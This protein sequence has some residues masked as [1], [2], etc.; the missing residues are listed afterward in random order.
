MLFQ[1]DEM[2]IISRLHPGRIVG[3][4]RVQGAKPGGVLAIVAVLTNHGG[5]GHRRP[6]SDGVSWTIFCSR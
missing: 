2:P 3:I 5:Q 1:R 4:I 6:D